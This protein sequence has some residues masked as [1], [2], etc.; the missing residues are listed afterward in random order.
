MKLYV[1]RLTGS[2]PWAAPYFFRG[3]RKFEDI[4]WREKMNEKSLPA[5]VRLKLR[6]CDWT[7]YD[8]ADRR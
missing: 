1:K 3:E 2:N 6:L 4:Q 5:S 7:F 8:F